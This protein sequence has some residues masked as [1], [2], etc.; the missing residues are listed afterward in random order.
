MA[1]A[2][3]EEVNEEESEEESGEESEE[4]DVEEPNEEI[5]VELDKIMK[6]KRRNVCVSDAYHLA[7]KAA[8]DAGMSPDT[9]KKIARA[10][11]KKAASQFDRL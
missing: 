1:K 2:E 5:A 9:S 10:A 11:Y 4:E 6:K 7:E 3:E 8:Y